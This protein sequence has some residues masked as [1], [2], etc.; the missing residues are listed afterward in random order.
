MLSSGDIYIFRMFQ[1][2]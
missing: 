2:T 1:V